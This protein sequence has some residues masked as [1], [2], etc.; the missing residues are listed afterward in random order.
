MRDL[1]R[2]LGLLAPVM[3]QIAR[4]SGVPGVSIGVFHHGGVVLRHSIGYRDL[5]AKLPTTSTTIYPIGSLSKAFTASIYGILVDEGILEWNT[6]IRHLLPEFRSRSKEVQSL[7]TAVDLLS[8]R[9]GV[10]GGETFYFHAQPLLLDDSSVVATFAEL[11]Q[12][13][14]FTAPDAVQQSR[15]RLGQ[16]GYESKNRPKLRRLTSVSDSAALGS[17]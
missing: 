2:T 14:P 13:Q 4:I 6:P 15:L 11:P 12:T 3:T 1:A 16:H 9:T 7:T 17:R 8:H 10:A 5:D